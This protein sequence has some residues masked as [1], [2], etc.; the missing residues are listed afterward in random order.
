MIDSNGAFPIY[1]SDPYDIKSMELIKVSGAFHPFLTIDVLNRLGAPKSLATIALSI[2]NEQS[3]FGFISSHS[4]EIAQF[5]EWKS[6]A[7]YVGLNLADTIFVSEQLNEFEINDI[8][9]RI[10]HGSSYRLDKQVTFVIAVNRLGET[11]RSEGLRLYLKNTNHEES[12]ICDVE[13]LPFGWIGERQL[14]NDQ[15]NGGIT[16]ILVDKKGKTICIPSTAE[17]EVECI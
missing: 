10:F 15:F 7:S 6:K 5:L 11:V 1:T 9:T 8:I 17:I 16:L 3:S 14:I 4:V 13:G 12:T 2:L